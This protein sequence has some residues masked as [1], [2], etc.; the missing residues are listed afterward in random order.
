MN[1][2]AFDSATFYGMRT[3]TVTVSGL[4]ASVFCGKRAGIPY[5][6]LDLA[7]EDGCKWQIRPTSFSKKGVPAGFSL[8][9]RNAYGKRGFHTQGVK[10]HG[11]KSSTVREMLTYVEQHEQYEAQ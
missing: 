1:F 7:D 3:Q 8:Y 9:H 10:G 6:R 11:T 2:T 4:T 5:S